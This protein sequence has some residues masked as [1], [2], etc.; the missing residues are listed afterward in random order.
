MVK[1][2]ECAY[3]RAAA[4]MTSWNGAC[5][6]RVCKGVTRGKQSRAVLGG[7]EI[8]HEVEVAVDGAAGAAL[9]EGVVGVQP[10]LP[11]GHDEGG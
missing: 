10:F 2:S 9:E 11:K 7:G 1:M 5:G 4:T 8:T 3:S 6:V